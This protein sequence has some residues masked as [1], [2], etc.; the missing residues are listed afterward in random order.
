M[1]N[2]TRAALGH[3]AHGPNSNSQTGL[4][5]RLAAWRMN[6]HSAHALASMSDHLLR[7]VGLVRDQVGVGMSAGTTPMPGD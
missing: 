5:G 4:I 2:S 7:D 1:T 3:S 6:R